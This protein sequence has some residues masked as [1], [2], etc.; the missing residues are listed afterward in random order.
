MCYS[1][2]VERI[3]VKVWNSALELAA[4]EVEVICDSSETFQTIDINSI[5]KLKVNEQRTTT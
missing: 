2:L 4:V 3:C 1:S 5:L